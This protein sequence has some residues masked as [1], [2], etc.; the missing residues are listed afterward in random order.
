[1]RSENERLNIDNNRL[2]NELH[3]TKV[4]NKEL[5]YI[6]ELLRKE[7]NKQRQFDN[8]KTLLQQSADITKE[9]HSTL[10]KMNNLNNFNTPVDTSDKSVHFIKN[11]LNNENLLL[12]F[13]LFNKNKK[14]N[15]MN[16]NVNNLDEILDKNSHKLFNAEKI[17]KYLDHL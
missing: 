4:E 6:N 9:S 5:L 15:N 7:V 16:L 10:Q 13:I 12:K 11:L 1:M 8:F 3:R 2:T 17:F 14:L